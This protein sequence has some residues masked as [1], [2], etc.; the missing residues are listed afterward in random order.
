MKIT[1]VL[2][3]GIA[4]SGG[5]YL[6]EYIANNHPE[7]EIHGLAYSRSTRLNLEILGK[8]IDRH[9][10][11][12]MDFGSVFSVLDKVRPGAIFH[13]AAFANVRASFLT[14]NT[15]FLSA[16]PCIPIPQ[17]SKL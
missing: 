5:S 17:F 4:G 16:S 9:E 3:T 15:F 6:A 12:L 2:I 10:A 14:P 13:L 8:K 7:V 1:K 11:D